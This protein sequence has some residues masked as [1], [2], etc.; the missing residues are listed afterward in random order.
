[1]LQDRACDV[2]VKHGDA[3]SYRKQDGVTGAAANKDVLGLHPGNFF[4]SW[5]RARHGSI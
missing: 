1:L 2:F 3:V 4:S 5:P